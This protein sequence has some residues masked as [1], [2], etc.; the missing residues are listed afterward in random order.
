M[1]FSA[2]ASLFVALTALMSC[3][4]EPLEVGE[5]PQL[6]PRIVVSTQITDGLAVVIILTKSV[7]ALEAS[8]DSDPQELLRQIAIND[9]TVIMQNDEGIYPL[10][11]LG[12]G[13]YSTGQMA[14]R[15]DDEY[16]LLVESPSMGTV[17]AST[18][19]KAQ[20]T[21][22]YVDAAIYDN[23]YDT[24]AEVAFSFTDPPGKNYYML[25]VQRLTGNYQAEDVINPEIFIE[26]LDDKTF[27]QPN[28]S[29]RLRVLANRDF[30]PGDTVGIFLSNI[31]KEY[32]DFMQVRLDSR[33]NFAEFLGEPANY[34]SNIKG[35]LGFFN[36]YI[37]DVRT[38]KLKEPPSNPGQFF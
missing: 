34:P 27:E 22:E 31:T 16:S 38:V 37:P 12:N 11:F 10:T 13:I 32:Y 15:V 3:L 4:P 33:F 23:G 21:F 26:L 36:L 9:A 25:N 30:V 24:L 19:V 18:E 28:Y 1:R 14:L 17:S 8:E 6:K 20:V 35:G 29:D 7:G 2:I 5:I